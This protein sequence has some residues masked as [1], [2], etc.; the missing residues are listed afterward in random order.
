[1]SLKYSLNLKHKSMLLNIFYFSRAQICQ[2]AF[3]KNDNAFI[4]KLME[5]L[6]Y[7]HNYNITFT[8]KFLFYPLKGFPNLNSILN[9]ILKLK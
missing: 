3:S 6:I 8:L 5:K 7:L 4:A 2:K 9:L 1:M